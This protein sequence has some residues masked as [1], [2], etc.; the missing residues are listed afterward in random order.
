[1]NVKPYNYPLKVWKSIETP[2]PKMKAHLK[3]CE[4]IPSHFP[5]ILGV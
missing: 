5:T 4:F 2:T 1:M 3:V